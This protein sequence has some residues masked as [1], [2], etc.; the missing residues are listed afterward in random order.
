MHTLLGS[1]G[2]SIAADF[3]GL[4]VLRNFAGELFVANS[5]V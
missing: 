3:L 1:E 5:T 2:N 4:P